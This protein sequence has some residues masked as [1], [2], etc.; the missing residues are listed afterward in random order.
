[1]TERHPQAVTEE[2][3]SFDISALVPPAAI[4]PAEWAERYREMPIGTT[5]FPGPFSY[6][7]T[8][9]CREPTDAL[10]DPDVESITCMWCAQGGKTEILLNAIAYWLDQDPDHVLVVRDTDRAARRFNRRRVRRMVRATD[11][12][13]RKRS[14]IKGDW[15]DTELV[16]GDTVVAFA[17]AH[18]AGELAERAIRYLLCDE[19]DKYPPWAGAD[20]HPVDLAAERTTTFPNS[21][22]AFFS[23][24]RLESDFINTRFL[25]SDQ[26][27]YH[28]PCPHCGEFQQLEFDEHRVKWPDKITRREL[29]RE[30]LA[31]YVC[32]H[33]EQ[34]IPDDGAHKQQMV[35]C[36]VW[37]PLGCRIDANGKVEGPTDNPHRGYHMNRLY[38]PFKSWSEE[39]AEFI[40]THKDATLFFNYVTQHLAKPWR[41]KLREKHIDYVRGL[42]NK[43]KMGQVPVWALVL[44]AGVDCK[45][46]GFHY[47]IRAWGFRQRSQLVLEGFTTDW[48]QVV[49]LLLYRSYAT[50]D[51]AQQHPVSF[52]CVDS[53]WD[54]WKVWERCRAY[55]GMLRPIKGFESLRQPYHTYF[56]DEDEEGRKLE[57]GVQVT[58]VDVTYYKDKLDGLMA[59]PAA[60]PNRW[61]LP[62]DVSEG[63]LAEITSE[64]KAQVRAGLRGGRMTERWIKKAGVS[65]NHRWDC[66]VYALLAADL[67]GAYSWREDGDVPEMPEVAREL[68]ERYQREIPRTRAPRPP[69]YEGEG[70]DLGGFDDL[71]DFL[72]DDEL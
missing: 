18:S 43:M 33:C 35:E 31:V 48:Q 9:Y 57:D 28:V 39:A 50:P 40:R 2:W 54:Q 4:T 63:Y 7:L 66:E 59:A 24:P 72:E 16:F 68:V 69:G 60:A 11:R 58:N 29:I 67:I 41:H 27:H 36:G 32:E 64:Q 62:G 51:G 71:E 70:D 38:S 23:T 55:P 30:R 15:T 45:V 14:R 65:A 42:Q 49:D 12:L 46:A 53:G 22:L 20:A 47:V 44:T 21:K 37:V 6:E 1:M 52:S 26:R 13:N 25:E 34:E 10:G 17:S 56:S 61:E 19:T 5:A 3:G 8:P